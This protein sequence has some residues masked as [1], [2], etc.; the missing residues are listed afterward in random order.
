MGVSTLT[1]VARRKEFTTMKTPLFD[2]GHLNLYQNDFTPSDAAVIGDLTVCTF[3]GYAAVTLT[4]YIAP[5]TDPD[6][7]AVLTTPQC[8]FASTGP[9]IVN[10]AF[11]WYI[12]D[13]DGDLLAA[14]RFDQSIPF[15][16]VG[17]AAVLHVEF[18]SDG[19]VAVVVV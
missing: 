5:Y 4:T 9:T 2:T 8:V 7:R 10:S 18:Y 16:D 1:R 3:S 15:A 12:L 6:G 17:D 19:R 11:G 14:G 13:A